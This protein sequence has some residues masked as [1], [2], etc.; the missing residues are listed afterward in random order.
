MLQFVY[1]AWYATLTPDREFPREI[2]RMLNTAFGELAERG[3][4]ID[5]KKMLLWCARAGTPL[6]LCLHA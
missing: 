4:R 1:D 2:R 3:R 5:L 6:T